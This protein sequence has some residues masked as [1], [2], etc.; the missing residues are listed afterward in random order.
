MKKSKY[1]IVVPYKDETILLFNTLTGAFI[2]IPEKKYNTTN[3]VLIKNKF[4]VPKENDEID[5]YKYRYLAGIYATRG[6]LITIAPTMLCNFCCPYCFEGENKRQGNMPTEVIEGVKK[7][8]NSKSGKPLSITWFGGEPFLNWSGISEISE[9][10]INE[11]IKF[12]SNAIS[13]GSICTERV[14]S[15]IDRFKIRSIQVTLDGCKEQHD[16]KRK[17]HNGA[18]SFDLIIANIHKLLEKTHTEIIIRVNLDRS[19]INSFADLQ[20]YLKSQFSDALAT[21]RVRISPSPVQNRTEFDGCS[22]CLDGDEYGEFEYKIFR[23]KAQLPHPVGPCSLRCRSSIGVGPD[24]SIYKCLEHFGDVSKAIGS[25]V[26]STVNLTKESDYAVGT[27]PFDLEE[28]RN[29]SI[30]PIC[31]GSCAIDLSKYAKGQVHKPCLYT[32]ELIKKMMISYY[33]TQ[34]S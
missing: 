4:V 31:G 16:Q 27:L 3:E 26:T 1:N 22:N 12:S 30:L 6:C 32:E 14:L 21:G 19:N 2:R 13:N 17:Y 23:Q 18:P 8:L 28:C 33:E 20:V 5:L 29:C 7:L 25:V 34:N 10:L 11:G 24:G 9:Y 15:D